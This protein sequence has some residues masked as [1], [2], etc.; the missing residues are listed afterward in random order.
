VYNILS[1]F[2]IEGQSN[3]TRAKWI[4]EAP[5]PVR[6]SQVSQGVLLAI[7]RFWKNLPSA[8]NEPIR[9]TT[10]ILTQAKVGQRI[11]GTAQTIWVI[12]I[13]QCGWCTFL[14]YKEDQ[15]IPLPCVYWKTCRPRSEQ[16]KGA[17]TSFLCT[18]KP[19]EESWFAPRE[20]PGVSAVPRTMLTKQT[21]VSQG[22]CQHHY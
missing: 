7:F 15:E 3:R 4:Q 10:L 11:Q 22:L 8:G 5:L 17:N 16:R 19:N 12:M 18:Q 6:S 2:F 13:H 1:C 20:L 9:D 21:S 14:R